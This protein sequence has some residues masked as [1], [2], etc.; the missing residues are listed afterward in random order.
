MFGWNCAA[1]DCAQVSFSEQMLGE[2]ANRLGFIME[3]EETAL[4]CREIDHVAGFSVELESVDDG[5]SSK[6]SIWSANSGN[7]DWC[8]TAPVDGDGS[9]VETLAQ[10]WAPLDPEVQHEYAD[11]H[12][13]TSALLG[14]SRGQNGLGDQREDL[15]ISAS[16]VEMATALLERNRER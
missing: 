7:R 9:V 12:Q 10:N 4:E 8:E 2:M 13:R 1:R 11:S 3:P 6:I 14:R 16:V 5:E 15:E